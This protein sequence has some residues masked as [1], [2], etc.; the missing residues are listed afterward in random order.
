[1]WAKNS[2]NISLSEGKNISLSENNPEKYAKE[3]ESKH[4]TDQTWE[5]KKVY[6]LKT[7]LKGPLQDYNYEMIKKIRTKVN[8]SLSKLKKNNI[9]KDNIE[10]NT[11][12]NYIISAISKLKQI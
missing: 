8:F 3:F 10:K 4:T 1:M 7:E 9:T 2:E 11:D 5:S 6:F 12:Y